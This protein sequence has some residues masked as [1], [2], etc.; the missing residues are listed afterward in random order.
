MPPSNPISTSLPSSYDIVSSLSTSS[1]S[2][3]SKGGGL[4]IKTAESPVA[5]HKRLSPGRSSGAAGELRLSGTE[6]GSES[7]RDLVME[8]TDELS[9]LLVGFAFAL[10]YVFSFAFSS[11]LYRN[12]IC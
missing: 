5:S 10:Q 9:G 1:S 11:D 4:Q 8:R 12:S 2:S 7:P 6:A 3:P